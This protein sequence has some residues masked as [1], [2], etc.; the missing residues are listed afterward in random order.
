MLP[1]DA[2]DQA[3]RAASVGEL[4]V[5]GRIDEGLG[6]HIGQAFDIGDDSAL[7]AV[8]FDVGL[9]QPREEQHVDAGVDAEF[10][11]QPL[12]A[13]RLELDLAIVVGHPVFRRDVRT[14]HVARMERLDQLA[15]EAA[16][17]RP[18]AVAHRTEIR[19]Q[20]R[21]AHATEAAGRFDQQHSRARGGRRETAA[22]EPAGP[23]P[24]TSTS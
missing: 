22:A 12:Q 10:V 23:P 16:D 7:D 24:A 18:L 15:R 4:R 6:P 9:D 5:A 13:F 2:G 8:P 20:P 19:N 11:E 3:G 17:E 1:V 21:G 14:E